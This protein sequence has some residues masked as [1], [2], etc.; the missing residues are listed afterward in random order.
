MIFTLQKKLQTIVQENKSNSGTIFREFNK[1][2]YK[3]Q[4]RL[5]LFLT[6]FFEDDLS[7]IRTIGV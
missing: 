6:L 1:D 3:R 7:I 5:P 4:P 2:E